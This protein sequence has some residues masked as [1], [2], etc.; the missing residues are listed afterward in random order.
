VEL[1]IKG[2]MI[3]IFL[4]FAA[5]DIRLIDSEKFFRAGSVPP[6]T[7]AAT[8]SSTIFHHPVKPNDNTTCSHLDVA[9]GRESQ[10]GW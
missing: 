3:L 10:P 9:P 6:E 7:D 5:V 4:N 1:A 2:L 8:S